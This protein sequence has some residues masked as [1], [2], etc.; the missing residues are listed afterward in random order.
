MALYS[1]NKFG[2]TISYSGGAGSFAVSNGENGSL[3][4]SITNICDVGD[5][6]STCQ[7]S[8]VTSLPNGTNLSGS[9][10]IEVLSGGLLTTP[11][12]TDA[13]SIS[14]GNFIVRSGGYVKAN[15]TQLSASS[16]TLESSAAISADGRGNQ[17]AYGVNAVDGFGSGKGLGGWWDGGGGGGYGGAGGSCASASKGGSAFG[18]VSAA[19]PTS[20]GSSGGAWSAIGGAGGGVLKLIIS[21]AANIAGTVS[22]NGATPVAMGSGAGGGSGGSVWLSVASIS[23]S[24]TVSANG[25]N[26]DASTN[27]GAGGGGRVATYGMG[28]FTGAVSVAG[29]TGKNNGGTGT[30]SNN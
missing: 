19:T 16:L 25:G 27:G 11:L 21:G 4:M 8:K 23:G 10:T 6:N 29:G 14:S 12:V 30:Y 2:G 3:Y 15:L 13:I 24:G 20:I 7:I 9:G 18:A 22:A 5:I 26:G 17:G 28:T 1:A